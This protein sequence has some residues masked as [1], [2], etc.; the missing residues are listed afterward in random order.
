MDR[1]TVEQR[2][3]IVKTSTDR[4]RTRLIRA[5]YNEATVMSYSRHELMDA[6]AEYSL[7]MVP[8][9][10]PQGVFAG[11]GSLAEQTLQHTLPAKSIFIRKRQNCRLRG[12]LWGLRGNV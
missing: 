1:V 4:L 6:Y 11:A 12:P 3:E 7:L 5:G 8:P 9:V 2:K 10:D